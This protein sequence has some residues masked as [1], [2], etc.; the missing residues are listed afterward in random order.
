MKRAAPLLLLLLL[1]CASEV[2][3]WHPFDMIVDAAGKYD[4]R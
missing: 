2:P 1:G 4:G 3:E